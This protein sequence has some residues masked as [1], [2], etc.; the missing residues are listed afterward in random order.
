M[1]PS[2]AFGPDPFR[3]QW[4]NVD[5]TRLQDLTWP[6]RMPRIHRILLVCLLSWSLGFEWFSLQ[7]VAWASMLVERSAQS[8]WRQAV[9][10][11]FDGQHPCHLCRVVQSAQAE[12]DDTSGITKVP[13]L[14]LRSDGGLTPVVESRPRSVRRSPG[15][16]GFQR[17]TQRSPI[18][19]PRCV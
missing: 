11:T 19:P 9:R 12:D 14:E 10:T 16:L 1:A 7:S 4:R 5:P 18:P 3:G 2:L 13:R 15:T 17:R 8:D 6:F